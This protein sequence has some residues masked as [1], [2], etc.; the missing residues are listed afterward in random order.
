MNTDDPTS[1]KYITERSTVNPMT[2]EETGKYMKEKDNINTLC[3]SRDIPIEWDKDG[4]P[5]SKH[6]FNYPLRWLEEPDSDIKID[7][8]S[9]P[10]EYYYAK[11]KRFFDYLES[12]HIELIALNP[13]DP[14]IILLFLN[15]WIFYSP[16]YKLYSASLSN[17]N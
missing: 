10:V 1:E 2:N 4:A 16:K 11:N 8:I 7:P 5:V 17:A 6:S 12:Q 15:G 13:S 9:H 14:T 3:L